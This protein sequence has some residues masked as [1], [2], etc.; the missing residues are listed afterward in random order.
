MP[1][2]TSVSLACATVAVGRLV[3]MPRL[4]CYATYQR[5]ASSTIQ[6]VAHFFKD[7]SVGFRQL[8]L[9]RPP[10]ATDE[11]H[12]GR[13]GDETPGP[14]EGGRVADSGRGSGDQDITVCGIGDQFPDACPMSLRRLTKKLHRTDPYTRRGHQLDPDPVRRIAGLVEQVGPETV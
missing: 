10:I 12:F 8:W 6:C 14:N 11:L 1:D 2:R 13:W 3:R 7:S 5:V 9:R 4:I